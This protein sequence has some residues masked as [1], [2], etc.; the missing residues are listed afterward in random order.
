MPKGTSKSTI[1]DELYSANGIAKLSNYPNPFSGS[2]TIEFTVEK[3]GKAV[4]DVYNQLGQKVA[5]L[6]EGEAVEGE[7]YSIELNTANLS[8]A[9]G[10]Y[11]TRMVQ[12]G[13]VSNHKMILKR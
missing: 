12:N 3:S 1:S 5:S 8:L 6:F 7:V 10:M 11:I 9:S 13:K 2:T 4:V